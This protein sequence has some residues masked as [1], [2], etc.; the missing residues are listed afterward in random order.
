MAAVRRRRSRRNPCDR[1]GGRTTAAVARSDPVHAEVRAP[2]GA[3]PT[4][5]AWR[6]VSMTYV[7]RVPNRPQTP[8]VPP[9]QPDE[10]DEQQRELLAGAAAPGIPA[11]NIFATLVR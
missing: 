4:G 10:Q 9:L 6:V 3:R 7:R 1:E 2:L 11:A 5:R 8:R